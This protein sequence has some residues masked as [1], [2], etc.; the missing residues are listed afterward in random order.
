MFSVG[1]LI[2]PREGNQFDTKGRTLP[3][4]RITAIEAW[5]K[6][7][8]LLYIN[9]A[10]VPFLSG[11]FERTD[12]PGD[13]GIPDSDLE[14]EQW[15]RRN[16]PPDLQGLVKQAGRRAAARLNE[17]YDPLRHPGWTE[18]SAHERSTYARELNDWKRRCRLRHT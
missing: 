14:F 8:Q 1:Q 11:Y 16:P 5:G 10:T 7:G 4:G 15:L 9:R 13:E 12:Q 3:A 2:K 6:R 18:L 17:P